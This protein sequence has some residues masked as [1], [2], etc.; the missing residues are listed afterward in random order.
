MSHF[1][2]VPESEDQWRDKDDGIIDLATA[3]RPE[4][5]AYVR[6]K[7]WEYKQ[8]DWGHH[9]FW[10]QYRD[11]F[12]NWTVEHFQNTNKS[13]TRDLRKYLRRRGV[14]I[15]ADR[16]TSLADALYATLHEDE[17]GTWSRAEIELF[18]AQHGRFH[19]YM[20]NNMIKEQGWRMPAPF[21]QRQ[22]PRSTNTPNKHSSTPTSTSTRTFAST[23]MSTPH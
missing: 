12:K 4:R 10:E 21:S 9:D 11:D 19:S 8:Y 23:S 15:K 7:C 5:D 2:A 1:L 6:Y 20:I 14:W 22:P 13:Y 3:S 17:H 18:I 16:G